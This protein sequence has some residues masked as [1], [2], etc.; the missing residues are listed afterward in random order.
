MS[1]SG[2]AKLRALSPASG[3]DARA[4]ARIARDLA[5]SLTLAGVANGTSITSRELQLTYVVEN[6]SPNDT[7]SHRI[8]KSLITCQVGKHHANLV[9]GELQLPQNQAIVRGLIDHKDL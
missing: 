7:I 8:R 1:N 2:S 6:E 3:P 4:A 5:R 9:L